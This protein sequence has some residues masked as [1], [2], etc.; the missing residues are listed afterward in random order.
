MTI[1]AEHADAQTPRFADP[2]LLAEGF[3]EALAAGEECERWLAVAGRVVRLRSASPEMLSR[4]TR[5]FAHLVRQPSD[6]ADLTISL[7]DSVA[8]PESAPDL[9]DIGGGHQP[10]A[11]F[12]HSDER[13]RAGFQLGTSGD[14]RVLA[15]YP[16][17][18]TPYVSAL[19]GDAGQAWHWVADASCI[20]Y[21]E[22]ATPLCYL[23]DWWLARMG[24]RQLHA[25]AVGTTSGG[26]LLVGK[27]GSGKS[28]STLA[29]LDSDL[30]FAG[31]DFVGVG[32]EPEPYV[33][34]LYASGKVMP[35]H[36]QRLPFLLPALSNADALASEKAVVY[37]HEQWPRAVTEGFPLKALLAP[38]VIPGLVESQA[39]EI[40]RGQGLAALAPSTVFQMHTQAG[41]SLAAMTRLV[42]RIPCYELQLGSDIG[43]IPRAIAELLDHLEET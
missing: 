20:P 8:A 12:Y 5:A 30:L 36:V 29:C 16:G 25:G 1:P 39:T 3:D 4:L 22:E 43:S 9:P 23:L 26:V 34:S 24:V 42:E 6:R 32:V 27:S 2:D 38:R 31:D 15:V 18:V 7:W 41:S 11:F 33:H 28:T 35:D 13:V 10:G 40:S 17:E 37:A 21:W 19:D 14:A